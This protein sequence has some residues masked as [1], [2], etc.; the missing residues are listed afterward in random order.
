[1]LKENNH[2][3]L[4]TAFFTVVLIVSMVNLNLPYRA[5]ANPLSGMEGLFPVERDPNGIY[6]EA[7]GTI[8]PA[9]APVRREGNTYTLTG[10]LIDRSIWVLCSDVVFD[11][12]G[13]SLNYNQSLFDRGVTFNGTYLTLKNLQ[14]NGYSCGVALNSAGKY[15]KS[16]CNTI[17]NCTFN[18]NEVGVRALRSVGNQILNNTLVN[19]TIGI[20]MELYCDENFIV[21]NQFKGNTKALFF[22][23]CNNNTITNNQIIQNSIYGLELKGASNNTV[24]CNNITENGLGILVEGTIGGGESNNA[25]FNLITN[26]QIA[27]NLQWGLVLNGSQID[28]QIYANNF[29]DNNLGQGLQVSIPMIME[30]SSDLLS[31][32][33]LPG[34]RNTWN[35]DSIGNY[36]S[37]Y[38]AR[39]PNATVNASD[40]DTPFY[41]NENNIDQH[42]LVNPFNIETSDI[43]EQQQTNLNTQTTPPPYTAIIVVAMICIIATVL[44]LIRKNS[45]KVT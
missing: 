40:W 21:G 11:G 6:I 44:I 17:I 18:N 42:P 34:Q 28:N 3:V 33:L 7:N 9:S 45:K 8:T 39:Y 26:N 15:Q 35:N 29:I 16:F 1:M 10:D 38:Q 30:L 12:A 25:C 14:V 5:V 20:Q 31:Y 19:N 41:I 27:K 37:D 22:D 36:W 2:K 43:G 23:Q 4:L 13:H 24:Y 32:K